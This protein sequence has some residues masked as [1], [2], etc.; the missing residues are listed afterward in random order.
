MLRGTMLFLAGRPALKRLFGG[1]LT[2]PLVRRFVAGEQIDTAIAAVQELN[3]R[4]ASAT[5]DYLG[6]SVHHA[7]A[8]AEA[9]RQYIALLHAITRLQANANVSLK[10]TQMGLD[11]D[12][13]MCRR[14]VERIVAQAAEFKNFVRIDMEGSRYTQ[15]TLDLFRDV[16]SRL[17][18][19]GVVIQAYLYR[20]E[21]DIRMLNE[22]GARVRLCKGAYDE[23]AEVA[24]PK[25]DDTDQNFIQLMR[26]LLSE[27]HYPAIATHDERMI[28]A[29]REYAVHHGIAPDRFEFQMLYGV[30]RDLQRQIV[31]DGYRLRVYVPYGDEWYPY[32]MRRMA[33]RPANLM[34]I[35]RGVL[36]DRGEN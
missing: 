16:Y 30:R 21:A 12:P 25:K 23:P 3:E 18:N 36:R 22:I 32:L 7:A 8:A 27:G 31:R 9:A 35:A 19:V 24:F 2:Q 34:F 13:D 4:G 6:E 29:T 20:S 17:P 33:E 14:H 28:A 5:L 26:L 1:S 15:T 10:L 11:V